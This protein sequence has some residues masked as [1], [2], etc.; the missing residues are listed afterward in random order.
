VNWIIDQGGEKPPPLTLKHQSSTLN[1]GLG[2][3]PFK[4]DR[5]DRNRTSP[6]AFTGNKFEF[7]AVGSSQSV[8][9]IVT[10]LNTI[11]ADAVRSLAN[12]LEKR[13]K[14]QE[15]PNIRVITYGLLRETL[16]KHRRVIFN[17]NGYSQEW[18]T[19]A[20]SRGLANV[21]ESVQAL[22]AYASEKNLEL[23]R[24]LNVLSNDEL[25]ARS[26]IYFEHYSRTINIEAQ[27]AENMASVL[28]LPASL[29]YQERIGTSIRSVQGFKGVDTT[30]QEQLLVETNR[31][32][33]QLIVA[34]KA[35]KEGIEK[36]HKNEKTANPEQHAQFVRDTLKPLIANVR[37]PADA[38]EQIVE[39]DLWVLP[40]YSDILF[41][42]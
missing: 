11:M 14:A 1:L 2:V 5:T 31:L 25:R 10:I 17:G 41:L 42:K 35:L 26:N 23:F 29:K 30:A 13:I 16:I 3:A 37:E 4:R 18:V 39:D 22:T 12:E 38:L 40:K 6:F 15:Q 19:E 9:H 20:A 28:V 21:K 32:I 24:S 34:N 36:A 27:V 7:R 33:N 8:G